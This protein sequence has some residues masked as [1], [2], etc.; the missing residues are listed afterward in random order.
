MKGGREEDVNDGR[1]RRTSEKKNMDNSWTETKW[2][3]WG[4]VGYEMGCSKLKERD[5]RR[6]TR[7]GTRGE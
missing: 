1:R 5:G 2:N 6:R 7:Y 3:S 4:I